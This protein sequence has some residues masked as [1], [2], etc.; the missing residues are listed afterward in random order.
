VW[1]RLADAADLPA[2]AREHFAKAPR[3]TV[4]WQATLAFFWATV[5]TRVDALDLAPDMEYKVLTQLIQALYLE[6][7]AGRRTHA[8]DC[9][10]L[11]ALSAPWL[12]PVH[13]STHPLQALAPACRVHIEAV[14]TGCADLF[15]LSRSCV[16]GRNGHLSLYHHGSHRLSDHQAGG[17]DGTAQFLCPSPRRHHRRRTL[18]RAGSPGAV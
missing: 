12:E 15:Q 2:C 5:Q 16:E 7:V 18:L 6:R 3:L 14:A 13:Q 4:Q 17:T 1:A 10:R 11:T 8:E 9:Q